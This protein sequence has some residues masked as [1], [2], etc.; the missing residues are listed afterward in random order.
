[1]D[2]NERAGRLKGSELLDQGT[3]SSTGKELRFTFS[4]SADAGNKLK[5]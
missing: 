3:I 2:N 4:L 5:E 1:M